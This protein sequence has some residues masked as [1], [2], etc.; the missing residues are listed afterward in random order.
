MSCSITESDGTA[1]PGS[2]CVFLAISDFSFSDSGRRFR[3]V[4]MIWY[5]PSLLLKGLHAVG[6]QSDQWGTETTLSWIC[7]LEKLIYGLADLSFKQDGVKSRMNTEG[8]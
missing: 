2:G 6:I 7:L 1:R 4:S 3:K 8:R 5:R